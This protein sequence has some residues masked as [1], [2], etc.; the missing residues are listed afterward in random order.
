MIY[1]SLLRFIKFQPYCHFKYPKKFLEE[2]ALDNGVFWI[3]VVSLIIF[4]IGLRI[5]GYFVLRCKV[6]SER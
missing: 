5:S 1:S 2:M 4:F 6:R 3:D